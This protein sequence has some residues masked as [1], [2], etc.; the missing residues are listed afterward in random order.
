MA[1]QPIVLSTACDT[2][3][4]DPRSGRLLSFRSRAAPE[5]EFVAGRADDPV[6]VLQY[7]D[8]R[9]RYHRL[10]SSDATQVQI[11]VSELPGGTLLTGRYAQLGGL[12]LDVTISV[13]ATEGDRFSHWSLAMSN[14]AGLL[15]ADVQFP[16]VVVAYDLGG[17]PGSEALLRPLNNGTL[18]RAPRPQDL[19]PDW[20]QAWQLIPENGD[21]M[22]YPGYTVAQ[23]LA[24]Y[25]DRAGVYLSCQ[26][27]SGMIKLIKPVHHGAG[28]RLGMAHIGDWPTQGE[29]ALEY[30]IVLGSFCGDWYAAAELYREWSLQQDWAKMPLHAREDVPGWLL[31]S[32]PHIILRIQGELDAGPAE[33]NDEFLPYV[34]TLP[35][36]D[37]LAERVQAPLMPV[38]MSWERPGPWIYPDCF[39]PAGGSAS[40][41]E[42]TEQCRQRG[43]RVGTFCNGTRWV[44]GHAWSGY[45][46]QGHYEQ[47]G[48]ER[49]ICRTSTGD[50]W[51]EQW[52][53]TWRPSYPC[54][55]GVPMTH[56]IAN[57]F[58][59]T[60]LDLGLDWVQFLDQNVSCCTFPCFATD[61]GHPPVPGRWMTAQMQ[62]LLAGFRELTGA[63]SARSGGARTVALSV[64]AAASEVFLPD[65]HL[66][67]VRVIP[68]GHQ[69]SRAEFVPLYH[70]LY[71]EFIVIQGGFGMGPEPYHLVTRNA[72]NLV[73]GQIPGAVLKGDGRLLNKDT[74]NWAPWEPQVG[75]DDDAVQ[76]LASAVA[77]RRGPGRDFLVYGRMLPPARVDGIRTQVWEQGNRVHRLPAVFHAAW[78]AP[79]GRFGL[80]LANWTTEAQALTVVGERLGGTP[81]EYRST[82]QITA[83]R[84]DA[85]AGGIDVTVPPLGCV[86]LERG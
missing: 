9:G 44:V 42:F 43:W 39:P 20:P 47:Q 86:L 59:Q 2:L 33:P 1:E 73:I 76:M 50:P 77:L 62:A 10:A 81:V 31:D 79:D 24:Y 54:C 21:N 55:L 48:G 22:H 26:D 53:A 51:R 38:I 30:D 18:L 12:P 58:V 5:Q 3:Q 72:Y 64:E 65:L 40:L 82:G 37:R 75:S 80:V 11:A 57:A 83:M 36:L 71:H 61:H 8:E 34:K 63:A 16:F 85:G 14:R 49:S 7:L 78:Q 67:D 68:P 13:R 29:R 4:F 17:A 25:N 27:G 6:F 28:I 69:V 35:L 84:R 32:P 52:D 41:F 19:E 74:M 66:C 60:L 23:F 70:Y 15:I 46:G 56:E 45:D